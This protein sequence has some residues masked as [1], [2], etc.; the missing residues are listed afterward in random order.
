MG[1]DKAMLLLDRKTVIE[2]VVQCVTLVCDEV[3]L[4]VNEPARYQFLNLPVVMDQTP[5][6]GPLVGLYS[7][8]RHTRAPWCLAVACD[9]PLMRT[10][11]L[12]WLLGC[13]GPVDAVLPLINDL[14]QPFPGLYSRTCMGAL[15]SLLAKGRSAVRDLAEVCR[16]TLVEEETLRRLDPD[17]TSFRDLDTPSDF[18]EMQTR[19][20]ERGLS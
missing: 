13:R 9:A 6:G 3:L 14:V 2:W 8:L 19:A 10:E 16:V 7:G 11:L 15:E 1:T 17:L 4:V 12:Q 20:S 18:Q 5:Y